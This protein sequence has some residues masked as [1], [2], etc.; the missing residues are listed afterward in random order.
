MVNYEKKLIVKRN[1]QNNVLNGYFIK[2]YVQ[3]IIVIIKI[4]AIGNNKLYYNFISRDMKPENFVFA[5]SETNSTLKL[6]DFGFS[7]MFVTN[8][9]EL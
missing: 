4:Y 9:I 6:I 8:N 5:T 3:L 2:C 1:F 7:K